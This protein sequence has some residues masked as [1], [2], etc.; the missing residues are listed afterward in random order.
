MRVG[1]PYRM[2]RFLLISHSFSFPWQNYHIY[3][4]FYLLLKYIGKSSSKSYPVC[5]I[6]K[7]S[8][9]T[10][11]AYSVYF[12]YFTDW[13]FN[14]WKSLLL[15]VSQV[16]DMEEGWNFHLK[17]SLIK[18]DYLLRHYLGHMTNVHLTNQKTNL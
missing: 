16:P 18:G 4:N 8:F 13:S 11:R 17:N 6:I 15:L 3:W 2:N 7:V 10:P 9:L 5:A 1:Y 14:H 12:T